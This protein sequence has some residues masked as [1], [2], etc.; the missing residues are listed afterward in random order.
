MDLKVAQEAH[1]RRMGGLGGGFASGH[2][3]VAA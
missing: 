1:T 3:E 2:S